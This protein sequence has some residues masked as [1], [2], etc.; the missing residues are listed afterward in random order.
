M[1]AVT[2]AVRPSG[3]ASAT[4]D[5]RP[6]LIVPYFWIGDY[7]RVHT[8]VKLLNARFPA[9]PV[10]MLTTALTAPLADYMAG[11]RK[12][13]PCDFPHGAL[14][15]GARREVARRLR[16]EGYGSAIVMP[17]T[18]KA[19]LAPYLAGIPER[20]GFFGEGRF[21]LLNDVRWDERKHTRM[22]D[23]MV[24]L[25]QAPSAPLPAAYPLPSLSVSADAAA[26][27]R[28]HRELGDDRPIVA[29]CP[30]TVGPGRSWPIARYAELAR[31]LAADG[32]RIW[33][34][35]GPDDRPLAMK[36]ALAGGAAVRD[37]TG[38]DLRDAI[39][40]LKAA[41]AAVAN[42]SGLLHVA[43]AVGARVVGIFG[44]TGPVT[45]GPL[46]PL[47][48]AIEPR[49]AVCATCGQAGC[50]RLDHRRT[51]DVPVEPVL[52]AV[53]AILNAASRSRP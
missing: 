4:A 48:A 32:A 12:A 10:D 7:V 20:T 33:V 43:A 49:L 14:A 30:A 1:D 50:R 19:A 5:T 28:T 17:R 23:R 51:D 29:L 53:R 11:V 3:A 38:P 8:A 39:L 42:D 16:G 9:R 45:H 34:L 36:I 15:L 46:N 52:D 13:I 27:W 31:R 22:V 47:A 2:D 37:L 21:L 18:L 25:T 26:A 35:G 6:I 41:D 40:A 44:P 24:A